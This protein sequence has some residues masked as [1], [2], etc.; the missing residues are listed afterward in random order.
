MNNIRSIEA[1]RRQYRS[2]ISPR[3]NGYL[4]MGFVAVVGIVYIAWQLQAVA[5]FGWQ[6]GLA[7]IAVLLLWNLI[8]YTVHRY[9]GH[10]RTV[11][12]RL[13]YQRHTG[14]HHHFFDHRHL[15]PDDHR[16]WRVTLFPA[17]LV[18]VTAVVGLLAG[19]V[20]NSVLGAPWGNLLAAGLMMGYLGY[21]FFHFCDHLRYDHPLL[22]LP[23]IGHMRRLH[24][25]HHRPD[26][27]H[28]KNFNLTF[29]LADW[30]FGTFYWERPEIAD[31]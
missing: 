17:W 31:I 11:I 27:M 1:F 6:Q 2:A 20:V 9:L 22:K 23:W 3:Y 13:F 26:L 14:D 5:V 8:E 10:R 15:V 30:L 16:D 28:K 25:L 12:G 7:L 19:W 4:H 29:P 21:E 18:L 24:Q